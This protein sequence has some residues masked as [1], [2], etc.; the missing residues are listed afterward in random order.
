MMSTIELNHQLQFRAVEVDDVVSDRYLRPEFVADEAAVA[1]T[2]PHAAFRSSGISA[3]RTRMP[4]IRDDILGI[5][6]TYLGTGRSTTSSKG[7]FT[8]TICSCA[9]YAR[10][11]RPL[12][13]LRHLLPQLKSAGGEG[14]SIREYCILER[15]SRKCEDP[16]TADHELANQQASAG[17]YRLWMRGPN[18]H[19]VPSLPKL[20]DSLSLFSEWRELSSFT[21]VG[22][23]PADPPPQKTAGGE[24]LSTSNRVSAIQVRAREM[25]ARVPPSS[26]DARGGFARTRLGRVRRSS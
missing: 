12:I 26:R 15:G 11:K 24:G 10:V 2:G 3:H 4:F 5:D 16:E 9:T 8:C 14:L 22:R 18:T 20:Q 6:I 19:I 13:R 17:L 21:A 23:R 25:Q 7:A 1:Q